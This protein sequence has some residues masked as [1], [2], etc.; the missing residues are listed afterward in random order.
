M[1]D[2][3]KKNLWIQKKKKFPCISGLISQGTMLIMVGCITDKLNPQTTFLITNFKPHIHTPY[4]LYIIYYRLYNIYIYI[5][6][7]IYNL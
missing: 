4:I 3:K 5:I 6:Y 7:Y 2:L 1:R